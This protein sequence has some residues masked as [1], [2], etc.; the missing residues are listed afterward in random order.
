MTTEEKL[1]HLFAAVHGPS[2]GS[3]YTEIDYN[4]FGE[5]IGVNLMKDGEV[6]WSHSM[7]RLTFEYVTRDL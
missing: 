4:D 6:C 5:P 7:E 2:T 3:C 1:Y